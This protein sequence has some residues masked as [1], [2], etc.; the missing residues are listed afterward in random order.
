M[1]AQILAETGLTESEFYRKFPT[2][3]S[4]ESSKTTKLNPQS[5]TN[6]HVYPRYQGNETTKT[7]PEKLP[8]YF[9]GQVIGLLAPMVIDMIGNKIKKGKEKKRNENQKGVPLGGS[10]YNF[11]SDP[12]AGSV[13]GG[14]R[15]IG[16]NGGNNWMTPDMQ[17]IYDPSSFGMN[18]GRGPGMGFQGDQGMQSTGFQNAMKSYGMAP[19]LNMLSQRGKGGDLESNKE[20]ALDDLMSN[21]TKSQHFTEFFE[22]NPTIGA[23][24]LN[25]YLKDNHK[26]YVNFKDEDLKSVPAFDVLKEPLPQHG[27]MG[28]LGQQFGGFNPQGFNP[29]GFNSYEDGGD[30]PQYGNFMGG[31]FSN[32]EGGLFNKGN[33][34]SSPGFSGAVGTVGS[35]GGS[36]IGGTASGYYGPRGVNGI[37][38]QG[39]GR[40]QGTPQYGADTNWDD[41]WG[42]YWQSNPHAYSFR[43]PNY[44]GSGVP[45]SGWARSYGG[46]GPPQGY[47]PGQNQQYNMSYYKHG[48]D[49]EKG[50]KGKDANNPLIAVGATPDKEIENKEIYKGDN[51]IY[52]THKENGIFKQIG[53]TNMAEAIGN[54]HKKMNKKTGYTGIPAVGGNKGYIF[55]DQTDVSEEHKTA[56]SR[57]LPKNIQIS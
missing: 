42:S 32:R 12:M 21:A 6:A 49:S 22:K 1:K 46:Y 50:Y 2:K 43:G 15:G 13:L 45:S 33:N 5:S 41:Y 8:K 14:P 30:L 11:L 17:G 35:G 19:L 7:S 53:E 25:V 38:G 24:D 51:P 3:E 40:G 56:S 47:N 26:V 55:S 44:Y 54:E 39:Q 28:N 29:Q 27:F 16:A 18:A 48:G 9:W 23:K 34:S 37:N 20:E 10:P 52:A 57:L 36:G 31:F 4:Y